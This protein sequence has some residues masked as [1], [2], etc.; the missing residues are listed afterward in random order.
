M[1]VEQLT[2]RAQRSLQS[3]DAGEVEAAEL[4]ALFAAHRACCYGLARQI[5]RDPHMAQDA[6]QDAFL[7]YWRHGAFDATRSTPRTW[8]LTLTH[9]KAVDRVRHEE[10]RK[11]SALEAV[12]DPA[13]VR[14]GPEDLALAS[15]QGL[16]VRTA[17]TALPHILREA[18]ELAYWGGYTQR[19]IAEITGVPLG[20][21]KSRMRT[22]M[23]T[24]RTALEDERD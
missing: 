16:T 14:R 15:V 18:L 2:P 10:R 6:V 7:Q 12:H 5:L 3:R 11:C 4:E 22:G 21:V 19:E 8:L 1:S 17:L 23:I 13:S 20:T 9:N 24:L